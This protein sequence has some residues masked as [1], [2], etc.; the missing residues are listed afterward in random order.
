MMTKRMYIFYVFLDLVFLP[1]PLIKHLIAKNIMFP[2][3]AFLISDQNLKTSPIFLP[4]LNFLSYAIS[5]G[6]N[7]KT[8]GL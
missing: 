2:T 7:Q 6:M 1:L 5:P 4:V 3:I 8:Q